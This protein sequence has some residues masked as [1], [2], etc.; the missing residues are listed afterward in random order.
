M[1]DDLSSRRPGS[2]CLVLLILLLAGCAGGQRVEGPAVALF[3]GLNLEGWVIEND[4]HFSVKEGVLVVNR[5]AGWLRSEREFEDF[6]LS[7]DVRFLEENANSGIFIRTA[8]TS[9]EDKNGWPD[10]GY[11][12]QCMDTVEGK[13]PLGTLIPYGAGP[14]VAKSDLDVLAMVYRSTGHWNRF[15]ITCIG[16]KLLVRLNGTVITA[17]DQITNRSGHVGIQG[18]HGLLEFANISVKV[19]N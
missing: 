9:G 18:E 16:R 14:F 17:A 12:V 3:N 4:G 8:A 19:I 15:E 5:G 2:L 6:V 1:G 7:L 10:N 13:Y 11:Q